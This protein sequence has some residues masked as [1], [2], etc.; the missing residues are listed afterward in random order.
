MA[1]ERE[2][3]HPGEKVAGEGDDGAPDLVL[4]EGLERQV[5]QS[6]VLRDADPVLTS[7]PAPAT[8]LKVGE[9]TDARV[10]DEHGDSHPV[11]VVAPLRAAMTRM[12]WAT[13]SVL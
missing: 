11:D 8:Q 5:A 2:H 7:G 12:P 4:G 3:A 13:R 10:G 1:G 6:G 9:L